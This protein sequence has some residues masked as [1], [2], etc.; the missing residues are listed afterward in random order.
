MAEYLIAISGLA[1]LGGIL[2]WLGHTAEPHHH[3]KWW[4]PLAVTAIFWIAG[5][6]MFLVLWPLYERGLGP[7]VEAVVGTIGCLTMILLLSLVGTRG[8]TSYDP[9]PAKGKKASMF[10]DPPRR[11][12]FDEE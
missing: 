1:I 5:T 12:Y 3:M 6:A 4:V 11:K 7:T 8:G 9:T 10:D 2:T